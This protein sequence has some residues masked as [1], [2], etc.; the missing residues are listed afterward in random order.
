M[1]VFWIPFTSLQTLKEN[2]IA[3]K[4]KKIKTKKCLKGDIKSLE[5]K[6]LLPFVKKRKS[7]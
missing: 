4:R 5:S 2:L 6:N 3:I 1:A 7:D